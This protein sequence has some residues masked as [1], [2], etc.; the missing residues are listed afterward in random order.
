MKFL[1]EVFFFGLSG[2]LAFLVD[3]VVLYILWGYLGPYSARGVSFL[4]AVATTWT[5]NRS[6]T[7][8]QRRSGLNAKREFLTYILL[9]LGGG[10]I[11]YGVYAWLIMSYQLVVDIPMIGVAAGSLSGMIVNFTTSRFMLYCRHIDEHRSV[12]I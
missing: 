3:T 11:N 9:M 1:R 4:A 12:E 8:K 6:V 2:F 5:F 7:F 10:A